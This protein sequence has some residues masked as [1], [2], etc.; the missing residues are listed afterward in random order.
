MYYCLKAVINC[1]VCLNLQIDPCT[2]ACG[3]TFCQLCLARL[4]KSN[5]RSCQVCKKTWKEFPAISY[6][7][8]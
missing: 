1:P 7:H 3:H 8:R 2:L 4:W 5:N 6:D